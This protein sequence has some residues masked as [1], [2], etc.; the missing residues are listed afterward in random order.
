M[1]LRNIGAMNQVLGLCFGTTRGSGA[2]DSFQVGLFS[3]DPIDN[4]IDLVELTD[5]DC[6]GYARAS[7]DSDDFDAPADGAIAASVTFPDTDGEWS[8]AATHW[9]LFDPV[10]SFWWD[11]N[12][13]AEPLEVTGAGDGPLVV[14]TVQYDN[15]L[16][17]DF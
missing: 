6:P 4:D 3:G 17:L 2:P 13:L 16:G 12:E 15:S 8:R 1:P 14:V 5:A 7:L 9:G 10:T 11:C